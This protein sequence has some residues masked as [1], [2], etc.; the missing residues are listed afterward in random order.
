MSVVRNGGLLVEGTESIEIDPIMQRRVESFLYYEAALLDERRFEE[1]VEL[2]TDDGF[3]W[4]PSENDARVE[5]RGERLSLVDDDIEIMRRR[6]KRLRHPMIHSQL[7]PTRT[8]RMVSNV[9]ACSVKE[10]EHGVRAMSRFVEV[11]SRQGN[12]RWFGGSYEHWLV[13]DSGGYRI[14]AKIVRLTNCDAVHMD[15]GIPF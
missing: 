4:V 9:E 14:R 6:V 5:E 12:D 10:P 1:W 8:S 13:E 11:E 3:L 7:P 2:Y 15:L